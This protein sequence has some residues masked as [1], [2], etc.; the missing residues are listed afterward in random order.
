MYVKIPLWIIK[1]HQGMDIFY[2]SYGESAFHSRKISASRVRRPKLEPNHC[3]LGA[4][5]S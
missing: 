3:K 1:L 4:M 2:C 5:Y